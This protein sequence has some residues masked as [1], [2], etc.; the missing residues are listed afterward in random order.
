VWCDSMMLNV[1]IQVILLR[2]VSSIEFVQWIFRVD[3]V[4]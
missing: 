4:Q 1:V 3:I 2:L